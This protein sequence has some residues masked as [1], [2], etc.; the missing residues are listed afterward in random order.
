IPHSQL[1]EG[2]IVDICKL[3]SEHWHH[4]LASQKK[5]LIEN[6][7]AK[8]IHLLLFEDDT[9]IGYLSL[10]HLSLEGRLVSS[11]I[12]GLGSVCV[13]NAKKGKN[14]GLLLMSLVNFY[15]LSNKSFGILL[16]KKDLVPFYKK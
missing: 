13:S 7:A 11:T 3:K 9:L 5:W 15:I 14:F 16:C 2:Q 10:V 12:L 8:D 1:N 6:F 4:D